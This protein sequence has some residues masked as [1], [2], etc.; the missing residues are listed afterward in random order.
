MPEDGRLAIVAA[1]PDDETIGLGA[2]LADLDEPWIF[3]IT[4]GAPRDMRDATAHGF[5]TREEYA[6]ARRRELVEAL[7]LAGIPEERCLSGEV[8]DQEGSSDLAGLARLLADFLREY[9]P[10]LV[11]APAYEGGHPDHDAAAFAVH[12]ACRLV[13]R[14]P[15]IQEYTLYHC[16]EGALV[17]FEFLPYAGVEVETAVLSASERERKRQMLDCFATQRET[18]GQFGVEVERRRPAPAYDF[19]Q[20]PRA[21]CIYYDQ[22]PW[23]IRSEAWLENA[24]AATAAL[25]LDG[26]F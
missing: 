23:G 15:A 14:P 20:P 2:R 3:H 24:R 9:R 8:A 10:A 17:A 12:A 19:S 26:A 6:R 1:H 7:A 18:L 11:F 13:E 21:G 5:R 16:S 25:G 4:D 22:F